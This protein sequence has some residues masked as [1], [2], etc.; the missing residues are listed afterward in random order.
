LSQAP[1][2]RP[3]VPLTVHEFLKAS[4]AAQRPNGA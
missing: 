2:L 3:T 1:P 4:G